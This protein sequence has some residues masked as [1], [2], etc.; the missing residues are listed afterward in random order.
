MKK[1]RSI[2][3]AILVFILALSLSGCSTKN[4]TPEAV[5]DKALGALQTSDFETASK[6]FDTDI[7]A[8]IGSSADQDDLNTQ[9]I[10]RLMDNLQYTIVSSEEN[11][12][13]AEVTVK[14]KNISMADVI[15]DYVSEAY[16]YVISNPSS[17]NLES[18]LSNILITSFDNN[19]ENLT[20]NEVTLSLDKTDNGWIIKADTDFIDALTGGMITMTDSIMSGTADTEQ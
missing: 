20:E 19:I 5:V 9:I 2:I 7:G 1:I 15:Q 4:D 3:T 16:S 18:E 13:T 14:I 11:D 6:Y 12:T 8:S 17:D 10:K